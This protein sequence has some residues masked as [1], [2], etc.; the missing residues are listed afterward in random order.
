MQWSARPPGSS[1]PRAGPAARRRARRRRGH[2][3]PQTDHD[4]PTQGAHCGPLPIFLYSLPMLCRQS[5][6]IIGGVVPR[7][8]SRPMAATPRARARRPRSA[9]SPASA[10]PAP[11]GGTF[12]RFGQENLPIVAPGQRPGRGRLLREAQ[13]RDGP[14]RASSSGAA[15]ASHGGPGRRPGAGGRPALRLRQAPD[16]GAERRRHWSPSRPRS[17]AE[18]PSRASSPGPP[19]ACARSPPPA[20]GARACRPACSPALDSPAVN[21]RGDVVFLA[22]VRRGREA[23]EARSW[24]ARGGVLRKVVAQ[25]DPAPAGG[26]FAAFGP[27]AV[28]ARGAVA[29][30]AVVEGKAVPGGVFVAS[31]ERI[32]MVGRRRRGHADRRHLRQVL[33]AHRPQRRRRRRVPRHAQ[34]RAGRG[35]DL[36]RSRTAARAPS[37]DS[38]TPR[39]AAAPSPLRPLARGRAPRAPSPS[40]PRSR[41]ARARW[42]S[43]T[44]G[45]RAPRRS[46]RS[47]TRFPGGDTHHHA[48]ALPGRQRRAPRP[49]D[50]RGGARP[51]PARAPRGSSRRPRARPLTGGCGSVHVVGRVLDE[52]VRRG[53]QHGARVASARAPSRRAASASRAAA[54]RSRTGRGRTRPSRSRCC[55]GCSDRS[56]SGRSSRR[57]CSDPPRGSRWRCR[58]RARPPPPPSSP[59][60]RSRRPSRPAAACRSGG[61][62][63]NFPSERRRPGPDCP[64]CRARSPCTAG[65]PL[66]ERLGHALGPL[67][68]A[69][70]DARRLPDDRRRHR[71]AAPRPARE[72]GQR[73]T[74]DPPGRQLSAV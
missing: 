9:R 35:G 54:P 15:T 47:A 62:A 2:E 46:S 58:G 52:D 51:P 59:P 60:A 74:R 22:T 68:H 63:R 28:N 67:R 49:R 40:P 19:A 29:F 5:C 73:L 61:A 65:Q 3:Q 34:V 25:G 43:C 33:R 8:R 30:A 44:A 24:R 17:P 48:H 38:A 32:Q 50:L 64:G 53:D 26:T 70:R 66:P 39:R 21:A 4:P 31:G 14:T 56:P 12:D 20:P 23:V 1:R 13:P 16:P 18:R 57:G 36:R 37:R 45:R 7:A 27:P 72:L 42:R 71:L 10:S 69:L 6:S 11:G 41:A 55:P